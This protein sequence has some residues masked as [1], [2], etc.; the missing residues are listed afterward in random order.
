MVE[1][2]D[3]PECQND[4]QDAYNLLDEINTSTQNV[5][6]I[7]D[8]LIHKVKNGELS[9]ANGLS[10]LEMKN[11]ML[12]SYLTNLTFFV[13]RKCTGQKIE[14]DPCIER[15]IE[16]KTVLEK[17]RPIDQKLKLQINRLIKSATVDTSTKFNPKLSNLQT[18]DGDIESDDDESGDE[19]DTAPKNKSG[20]YVPPKL[21]A[22]HYPG[23]ENA[24]ERNKRLQERSKK[25]A[26]S[27]AILQD[28][29]EEY[30]DTPIEVHQGSRAQQILTKQQKERQEYEE[31]YMTRLPVTKA[32]KHESRKLTTLGV[33]GSEVTD[34]RDNKSKS[35]GKRKRKMN[36]KSKG[37]SSK[38]KKYSR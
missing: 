25:H 37:K 15:L 2:A 5:T 11:M 23:E 24:F 36:S 29:C 14:N 17:I 32:E 20:V 1:V 26:I 31:E 7:V 4:V 9:T 38:R 18:D 27:S 19:E 28:L 6:Q 21:S 8:N 33:L 13:S 34:Y 22:V 10:F 16:I 30:L 35:N 12:L 3:I